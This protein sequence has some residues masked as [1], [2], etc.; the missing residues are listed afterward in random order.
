MQMRPRPKCVHCG[1][2]YGLR[3]VKTETIKFAENKPPAYT[4]DQILVAETT[5]YRTADGEHVMY[6]RTWDGKTWHV[7]HDPFCTLRCALR[8]ARIAFRR[9]GPIR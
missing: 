9:I 7:P 6:R 5:P 1:Q 4:G 3:S 2:P 8:Y